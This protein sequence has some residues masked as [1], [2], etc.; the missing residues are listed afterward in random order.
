M[1]CAPAVAGFGAS[2]GAQ[3]C[4]RFLAQIPLG[5]AEGDAWRKANH[6]HVLLA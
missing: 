6:G 5:R 4:L 3:L 2:C 1:A